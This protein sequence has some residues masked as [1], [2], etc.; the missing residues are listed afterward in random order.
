M[1][2]PE[3][4]PVILLPGLRALHNEVGPESVHR[5]AGRQLCVQVCQ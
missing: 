2:Y 1:R 3:G 5:E 4:L